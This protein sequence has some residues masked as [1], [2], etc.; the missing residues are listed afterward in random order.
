MNREP[1][2]ALRG[3]VQEGVIDCL[4]R[5]ALKKIIVAGKWWL[6]ADWTGTASR[7]LK[8]PFDGVTAPSYV[9][10]EDWAL[11]DFTTAPTEGDVRE[12]ALYLDL[13]EHPYP[14]LIVPR[15]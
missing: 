9:T 4:R 3:L 2:M 15:A 13:G 10:T 8:V 7:Y 1:R 6:K 5:V 14:V 11:I 12:D